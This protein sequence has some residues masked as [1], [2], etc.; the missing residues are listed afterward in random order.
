MLPRAC[1]LA[2]GSRACTPAARNAAAASM[3]S[4]RCRFWL[5]LAPHFMDGERGSAGRERPSRPSNCVPELAHLCAFFTFFFLIL[6]YNVRRMCD[7]RA[8]NS[9]VRCSVKPFPISE[10]ITIIAPSETARTLGALIIAFLFF[11]CLMLCR[12]LFQF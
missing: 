11:N 12:H 6:W 1:E 4:E 9:A 8:D 2:R 3:H 5:H 10:F 7:D